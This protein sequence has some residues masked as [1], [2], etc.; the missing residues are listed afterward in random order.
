MD[1]KQITVVKRKVKYPRLE[2]KSGLPVLILPQRGN[3]DP[4]QVIGKHKKW[5][6]KKLNFIE[7]IKNKYGGQKIYQRSEKELTRIV[8]NLVKKYL[9]ILKVKPVKI[10]FR[11]MKTRW[12]SCSKKG[13]INLNLTLKHLPFSLIRYLIFHEMVHLKVHNHSKNFWL[14]IKK[15][16]KDY[17][18]YEEKLFGYW[19]LVNG[20]EN[21]S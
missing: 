13:S 7:K 12:G 6:E 18:K 8:E 5:L 10:R 11:Y 3:F 14:N 21:S 19:F 2:L 20:G 16:F 15:E 9:K 4:E 17:K 1:I